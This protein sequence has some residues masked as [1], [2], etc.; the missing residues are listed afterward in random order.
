VERAELATVEVNPLLPSGT[1]RWFALDR[2]PYHGKM[3]AIV[4]DQDGTKFGKG[5]G[6]AVYADGRVIARSPQLGRVAGRL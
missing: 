1:W 5:K 2:I 3:L 4:W 6:L